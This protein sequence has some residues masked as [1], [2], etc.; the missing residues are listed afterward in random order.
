MGKWHLGYCSPAYLPTRRGFDTFFGELAQQADHYTREHQVNPS[1]G[2]GYDLWRGEEVSYEGGG[3]YSTVL[4]EREAAALLGRL[5]TTT[6][7]FLQLSL[8]AAHPPYQAPQRH[9][10][11][12]IRC[13]LI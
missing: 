3:E 4:W 1:I 11:E 9:T 12:A 13:H 6:P 2:S 10:Q 5:N 8:T 7:W